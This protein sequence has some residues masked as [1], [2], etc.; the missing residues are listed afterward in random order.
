MSKHYR[1]TILR[2]K[3]IQEMTAKHYE[4]GNYS[5]SY[6]HVWRNHISKAYPMSYRTFLKYIKMDTSQIEAQVHQS[7]KLQLVL[8]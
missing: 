3:I 5:R 4:P 8:F 6:F 2:A 1:N 7:D